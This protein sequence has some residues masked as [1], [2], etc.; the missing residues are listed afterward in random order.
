MLFMQFW[1]LF[2]Q[3]LLTCGRKSLFSPKKKNDS[4]TL[5][6]L[7]FSSDSK[8]LNIKFGRSTCVCENLIFCQCFSTKNTDFKKLNVIQVLD[9]LKNHSNKYIDFLLIQS[10]NYKYRKVYA[11]CLKPNS[12]YTFYV[13]ISIQYNSTYIFNFP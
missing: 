1:V 4:L 6:S 13:H 3:I 11:T 9:I 5:C 12:T 7:Y 8:S 10:F 2:M